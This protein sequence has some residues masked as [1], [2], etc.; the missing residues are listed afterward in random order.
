MSET[1]PSFRPCKES[2]IPANVLKKVVHEQPIVWIYDKSVESGLNAGKF[3][4]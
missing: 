2:C 1:T 3:F 4:G